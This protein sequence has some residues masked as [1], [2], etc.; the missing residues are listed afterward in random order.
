MMMLDIFIGMSELKV[1]GIHSFQEKYQL[2]IV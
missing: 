2:V 1:K